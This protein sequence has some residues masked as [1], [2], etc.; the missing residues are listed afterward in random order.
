MDVVKRLRAAA[1]A[2]QDGDPPDLASVAR[3]LDE[4]AGEIEEIHYELHDARE[5]S[6]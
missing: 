1:K 6:E 4:A 2:L 3:L 5:R